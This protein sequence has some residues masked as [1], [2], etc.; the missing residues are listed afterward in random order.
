ES[1]AWLESLGRPVAELRREIAAARYSPI[2]SDPERVRAQLIEA[3]Q[4]A[5]PPARGLL[6]WRALAVLV[7]LAGVAAV[8]LGAPRWGDERGRIA[9]RGADARARAGDLVA[10][11]TQWRALWDSGVDAAQLAA[12]LA[13]AELRNGWIADAALWAL[14]GAG[15]EPRDAALG[16]VW[17]R[18]RESGGLVGTEPGRWPV[19]SGEWAL[20]AL[21]FAALGAGAWPRRRL[22]LALAALALA[23]ALAEPAR[24]AL[25]A[26][27]T[28]A[29]VRAETPLEGAGVDLSAGQVVRVRER[30]GPRVRVSAGRDL[31]GWLP[32]GALA[33]VR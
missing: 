32:A 25:A 2:R 17:E 1:A 8:A 4:H 15:G 6:L 5:L 31:A 28:L 13:W 21:L 20:G 3:L 30:Q 11:R 16:W 18:V 22:Q 33:E 7:G 10:A 26:R 27:T 9:A 12:R 24:R 29:V 14:R 19:R 23:C